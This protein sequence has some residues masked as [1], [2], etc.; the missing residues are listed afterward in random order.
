LIRIDLPALVVSLREI[1]EA[2]RLEPTDPA[3]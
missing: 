2:E 3:G 1:L